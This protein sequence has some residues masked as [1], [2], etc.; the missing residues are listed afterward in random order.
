M[1]NTENVNINA[2][3]GTGVNGRPDGTCT[4]NCNNFYNYYSFH[5]GGAHFVMA[6]GTVRFI[7]Q[8][9]DKN[10]MSRIFSYGDGSPVGEF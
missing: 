5:T 3:A 7:S 4:I 9:V 2:P 6:D 8:N 10:T 1:N